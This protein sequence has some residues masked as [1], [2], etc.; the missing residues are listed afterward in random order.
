MATLCFTV[1][2][3]PEIRYTKTV[4]DSTAEDQLVS[5]MLGRSPY[6]SAW[7]LID[8]GVFLRRESIVAVSVDEQHKSS[9]AA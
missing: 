7:V 8:D 6:S 5:F 1:G 3:E 9:R 4:E 2:T